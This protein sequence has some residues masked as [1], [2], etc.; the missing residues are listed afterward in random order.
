MGDG[1]AA[2]VS[3]PPETGTASGSGSKR[4]NASRPTLAQRAKATLRRVRFSSGTRCGPVE[5]SP[6]MSG[7][8]R[9]A[10]EFWIRRMPEAF[11]SRVPGLK[12]AVARRLISAGKAVFIDESPVPGNN[13]ASDKT[14][15]VSFLRER[16]IVL[17]AALFRQRV[18]LGRI[19][20]HELCHFVW[21]RLG[22]PKRRKFQELLQREFRE[23][24]AGEL[25]YSS[26]FRKVRLL[27]KKKDR[28]SR[29]ERRRLRLDYICESF[30][31][32]GAFVLLG[33]ERRKRHSEFT[34]RRAALDRRSRAW[35]QAVLQGPAASGAHP[36]NPG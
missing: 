36:N 18:E 4:T 25:G 27:G 2:R 15:A 20:Y 8:E 7:E 29:P 33:S 26:E 11:R 30:C 14:H 6:R 32:T 22:N 28:A 12:L 1:R 23:R 31:D 34:L 9:R 10:A 24:V 13:G 16:Y 17:G 19:L 3:N 35:T 21:P 5:L